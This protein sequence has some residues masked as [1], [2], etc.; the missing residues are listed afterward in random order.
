M[1]C[2]S[3]ADVFD[4]AVDPTWREDL[5][6]LIEAT[7]NLDW[8][9]LTKRI[10]NVWNM[11]PVP[12]D[13]DRLYPNVWIGATIVNQ[14]EA[15]RD[16]PKLLEVPARVRFLSMEPLL[17]PVDLGAACRRAGLHLGEALDWVIVGGESGPGARPMHPA[18]AT[19]LR[20]QC[21]NAGVPFLSQWGE[22]AARG[23]SRRGYL[24]GM[25]WRRGKAGLAQMLLCRLLWISIPGSSWPSAPTSWNAS[26]RLPPAGFSTAA[27]GARC[28]NERRH[29]HYS[30]LF[31]YAAFLIWRITR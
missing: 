20:D 25:H 2:A 26:A 22:W 13:F 8:L 1:F 5:F 19:S 10:G 17:G 30:G 11:L 23:R 16:I 21:Q 14:A 9:L 28:R 6:S 7:P 3:L 31:A 12:F 15:D 29:H 27:N 18:W 24:A 4:N